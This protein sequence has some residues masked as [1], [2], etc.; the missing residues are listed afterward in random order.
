METLPLFALVGFRPRQNKGS[1]RPKRELLPVERRQ[2]KNNNKT[3]RLSKDTRA[4]GS[5]FFL[6]FTAFLKLFNL[7]TAFYSSPLLLILREG[8]PGLQG[9]YREPFGGV[10]LIQRE[11]EREREG[12]KQQRKSTVSTFF[13][14][15]FSSNNVLFFFS[16][17]FFFPLLLFSKNKSYFQSFVSDSSRRFYSILLLQ[18]TLHF[19]FERCPTRFIEPYFL[20][21]S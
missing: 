15:L 21:G 20:F 14:S 5:L 1:K 8:L 10:S 16:F 4:T 12:S 7:V 11:R 9:Q 2:Q 19:N 18:L 6:L 3:R 17:F 13:H